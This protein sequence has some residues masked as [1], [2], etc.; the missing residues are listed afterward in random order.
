MPPTLEV[1]SGSLVTIFQLLQSFGGTCDRWVEDIQIRQGASLGVKW[2]R[3]ELEGAGEASRN[4]IP[5]TWFP[6]KS[7]HP[8]ESANL[9]AWPHSK[10][11]LAFWAIR[12]RSKR[13]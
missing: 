6:L 10:E 1:F 13:E 7:I 4:P 2:G 11:E 9:S 12:D 5:R 8:L 3:S